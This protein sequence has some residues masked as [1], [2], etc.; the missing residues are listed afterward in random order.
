M[1]CCTCGLYCQA[2][3]LISILL[4]YLLLH[5]CNTFVLDVS[6]DANV[7]VVKENLP[8]AT[9]AI[10]LLKDMLKSYF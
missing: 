2:E 9:F 1:L 5:I 8:S 7:R 6:T 10:D 3:L 4:L